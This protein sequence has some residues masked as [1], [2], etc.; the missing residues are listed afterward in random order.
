[1]ILELLSN[2]QWV[3]S[4]II[5]QLAHQIDFDKTTEFAK[6]WFPQSGNRLVVL[7]PLVS[8]GRPSIVR[9]GITT[10][11]IYDLYIAEERKIDI[12]CKWLN[13]TEKEVT[14][15]VRFESRYAA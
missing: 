8:F 4:N 12:I 1:A 3:I 6:R 2:G 14:A 13:L 5:E 10:E 11:N 7:D 9:K 15:A